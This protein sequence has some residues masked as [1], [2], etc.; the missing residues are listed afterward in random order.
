M[1][2][3][4]VIGDMYS[5]NRRSPREDRLYE[6]PSAKNAQ[7]LFP[8]DAC[9]FVGNLSIKVSLDTLTEDLGDKFSCFGRCHVK[10]KQ[11]KKKGLPGAF[12]QF[13]EVDAASAA[14]AWN[15]CTVMH[16]RWLRVERARGR[17]TA[18][19]GLRC[20]TPMSHEDL[21]FVLNG[22]GPVEAYGF[23]PHVIN[24]WFWTFIAKVT[25]AY[26]DDC[27][28]MVKRFLWDERYYVV[29][30]DDDGS[31]MV[32]PTNPNQYDNNFALTRY[33]QKA[34]QEAMRDN[35]PVRKPLDSQYQPITG[36]TIEE[37]VQAHVKESQTYMNPVAVNE[38]IRDLE[39]TWK[40]KHDMAEW[41]ELAATID[42]SEYESE[43]EPVLVWEFDSGYDENESEIEPTSY[44]DN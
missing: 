27:K 25:F 15:E 31:P 34:V 41:F 22:R 43:S 6:R 30:L 8:P 10:I 12:V 37:Y 19:I 36:R 39:I 26:V 2:I 16:D 14:L 44:D 7:G 1:T 28:D 40:A 32:P 35:P 4:Y 21:A 11:D 18:V 13:E 20:M 24:E 42:D 3:Q 38:V 33:R 29:L 5:N 9:V 17:R 23:E